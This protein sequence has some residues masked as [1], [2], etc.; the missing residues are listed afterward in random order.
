MVDVKRLKERIRFDLTC[1]SGNTY[2][3]KVTSK[4]M[5][6]AFYFSRFAD[7]DLEKITFEQTKDFENLI[8]ALHQIAY[9]VIIK[10][11][12][13]LE[14]SEEEDVLPVEAIPFE[15][16]I[17]IAIKTFEALGLTAEKVN[18]TRS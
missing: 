16:L 15:D 5:K 13:S 10:P 14:W 17:E 3:L 11:K 1:K 12:V 18:F 2:T 7:M 9:N 6:Y 4:V 8:T